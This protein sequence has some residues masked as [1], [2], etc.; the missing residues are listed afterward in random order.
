MEFTS[1]LSEAEGD[2]CEGPSRRVG[3]VVGSGVIRDVVDVCC[4]RVSTSLIGTCGWTDAG[5]E[6]DEEDVKA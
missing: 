1:A 3:T 6:E 2:A 4:E 5:E